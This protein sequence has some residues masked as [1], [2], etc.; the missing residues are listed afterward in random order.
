M[1]F[2][3]L[4]QKLGEAAACSLTS[5][6][7]CDPEI[8]G[9]QLL[10]KQPGYSQLH[11]GENLLLLWRRPMRVLDFAAAGNATGASTRAGIAWITTPNAIF[12][13]QIAL[14][15]QP[16]RPAPEIPH[17]YSSLDSVR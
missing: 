2:S 1:K 11:R 10:S 6:N 7:D 8:T 9:W 16:F 13:A 5:N 4:V 17:R 15:Y 3:E 12:V 14:F